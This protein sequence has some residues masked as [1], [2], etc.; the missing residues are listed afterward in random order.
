MLSIFSAAPAFSVAVSGAHSK[1]TLT[2]VWVASRGVN[3]MM[4][5][6]DLPSVLRQAIRS[7]GAWSTISVSNSLWTPPTLVTQWLVVS[8]SCVTDS[9]PD[10][11]CGN[12]SNWVH[13][14]YAVRTGTATST[15]SSTSSTCAICF[16]LMT[17]GRNGGL[18]AR[19]ILPVGQPP[20]LHDKSGD[21]PCPDLK[22]KRTTTGG[23]PPSSASSALLLAEGDLF[24]AQHVGAFGAVAGHR[25]ADVI[26]CVVGAVH[27]D[28]LQVVRGG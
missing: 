1:W 2:L 3:L 24:P 8:V 28:P 7:S 4:P 21:Y 10:M 16:L 27:R 12:D 13:W 17:D 23:R 20:P 9:T 19:A 6:C 5:A 15:V 18:A 22:R 14:L 26:H 25:E 11:N